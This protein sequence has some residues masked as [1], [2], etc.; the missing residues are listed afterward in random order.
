MKYVGREPEPMGNVGQLWF[1]RGSN[2][3]NPAEVYQ[4]SAFDDA[5][6]KR[7]DAVPEDCF[8]MRRSAL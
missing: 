6:L 7:T 8:I 1:G 2:L 3:A 4:F 5:S